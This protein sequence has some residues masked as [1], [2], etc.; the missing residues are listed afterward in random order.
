MRRKDIVAPSRRKIEVTRY[1]TS[2]GIC[3]SVVSSKWLDLRRNYGEISAPFSPQYETRI[4]LSVR[5]DERSVS[6]V[7]T[8]P[9]LIIFRGVCATRKVLANRDDPT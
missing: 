6:V 7:H 3:E 1:Q 8:M 4:Q 2:R 5:G 9:K